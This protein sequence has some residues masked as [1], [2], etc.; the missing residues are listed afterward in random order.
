[1]NSIQPILD[2]VLAGERMSIE[3]CTTLLESHDIARMGVA[4]DE[5]RA[6]RHPEG[7]DVIDLPGDVDVRAADVE[8][9]AG[10][11]VAV[12][13]D[14]L[15]LGLGGVVEEKRG[16]DPN[17]RRIVRRHRPG[18]RCDLGT[19]SADEQKVDESGE[20][21]ETVKTHH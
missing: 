17:R 3:Q 14:D 2:R 6:R 15:R 18:R 11:R 9:I 4:A 7:D 19:R 16:T 5:I 1:M 13:V 12:G 8:L 21:D 20:D 10:H